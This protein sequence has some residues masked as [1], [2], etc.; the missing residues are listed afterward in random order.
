MLTILDDNFSPI[1]R[2]MLLQFTLAGHDFEGT[3]RY[4]HGPAWSIASPPRDIDWLGNN[5]PSSLSG[6]TPHE[7]PVFSDHSC[8]AL[9]LNR[10]MV[11]PM[12][13]YSA[14]NGEANDW[15]FTHINTLALSGAAMFCIEATAVEA[16]GRSR[17]AASGCGTTP[18]KPR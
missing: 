18:P 7:R 16:S 8:A 10:I 2:T 15:H 11:A 4:G 13:Q 5:R 6:H 14:E 3:A 12:C 1:Q 17:R 9:R